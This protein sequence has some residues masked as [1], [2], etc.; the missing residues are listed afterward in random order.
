MMKRPLELSHDFLEEVL[1]E[2][3]VTVDATMGNGSDTLFL[4]QHSKHV[5]AFDVQEMA[6]KKTAERLKHHGLSNVTLIQDG[7]EQVDQY[8]SS[9]R[10]AIFNL[11]YLPQADKSIIT[12]PDTTLAALKKL[13]VSLEDGGRIAIMVYY[14]HDGGQLEKEVLLTFLGQLSQKEYT[15]MTYQALNQINTP[16]FLVMIEKHQKEKK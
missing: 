7:H 11:G 15:V 12:R 3:A 14:G 13:L 16:P 8:V 10:A 2:D 5:Y 1:D 9:V 6:L 4:A